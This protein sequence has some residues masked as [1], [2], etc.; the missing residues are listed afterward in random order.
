[1]LVYI[2]YETLNKEFALPY[3]DPLI[4]LKKT[5]KEKQEITSQDMDL[6]RSE[7]NQLFAMLESESERSTLPDAQT[8]QKELEDLLVRLRL[9]R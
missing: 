4:H 5:S 7:F 1:M 8:A 3:I 2:V 6:Y 9:N